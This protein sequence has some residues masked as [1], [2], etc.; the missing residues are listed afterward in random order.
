MPHA[1]SALYSPEIFLY[2]SVVLISARGLVNHR[3]YV[4]ETIKSINTIQLPQW[5]SNPRLS[6]Q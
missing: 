2:F 3:A 5:I 4:V 1:L 6:N